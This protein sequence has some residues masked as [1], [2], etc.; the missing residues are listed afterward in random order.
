MQSIESKSLSNFGL[1]KNT[2][3]FFGRHFILIFGLGVVAAL[4]RAIQL[5]ARGEVSGGVDSFLE[6]VIAT[7]RILTF[8]FVLGESKIGDGV[9]RVISVFQ[10]DRAQWKSIGSN[11]I[12]RLKSNWLALLI[13]LVVYSAI[14]MMINFLIDNIAYNS[15]LLKSLQNSHILAS[16]TTEW[17]LLLFFKNITVIPFTIIFNAFILLWITNSQQIREK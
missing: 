13:N 16:N 6:I 7:A 8:L 3:E 11:I 2:I 1:V 15:N 9:K 12:Y 17:V 10:L 5:G 14:A 4:G